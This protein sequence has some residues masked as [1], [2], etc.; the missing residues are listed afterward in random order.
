MPEKR[1]MALRKRQQIAKASQM[2]FIWVAGASVVVGAAAVL[3]WVLGQKLVFNEKVLAVKQTTVSTLEHNNS[4]VDE[5]KNQVRVLNTNQALIDLKTP[6]DGDPV[7]VIL[8]A[9]PATANSTALGASLQSTQLLS[10]PGVTIESLSVTPVA[11]IESTG[12]DSGSVDSTGDGS[13]PGNSIQ[14]QFAVSVAPT[15]ADALK[16]IMQRL[17]RSIRSVTISKL[18]VQQQGDSLTMTVAGSAYYLPAKQVQ[19]NETKVR[20]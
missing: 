15:N 6:A 19:L 3:L 16:D 13:T 17:E 20:P 18:Q 2:M 10:Q 12:D 14:F 7:Q 9:L 5:L 4:I 11:G 1:D 8:D